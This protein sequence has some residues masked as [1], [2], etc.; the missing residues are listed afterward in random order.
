MVI[1]KKKSILF[2]THVN[3]TDSKGH[4][5]TDIYI[6]NNQYIFITGR[7]ELIYLNVVQLLSTLLRMIMY[8]VTKFLLYGIVT[9]EILFNVYQK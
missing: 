9:L 6:I 8:I 1:F 3:K 2:N 5:A 7:F 4:L